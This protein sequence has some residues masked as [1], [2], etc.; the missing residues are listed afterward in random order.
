MATD[1]QLLT[2]DF[3][4]SIHALGAISLGSIDT[5][6]A[7]F[8]ANG[9]PVLVELLHQE[10]PHDPV[11]RTI[12]LHAMLIKILLNYINC[13]VI[14]LVLLLMERFSNSVRRHSYFWMLHFVESC[15]RNGRWNNGRHH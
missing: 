2:E 11:E 13:R 10:V 8:K 15:I 7:I 12:P 3:H 14:P 6:T 5:V 9:L 1:D 4:S